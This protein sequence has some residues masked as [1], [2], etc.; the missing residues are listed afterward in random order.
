MSINQITCEEIPSPVWADH[1]EFVLDGFIEVWKVSME[2]NMDKLEF[3]ESLLDKDERIRAYR[4]YHQRDRIRFIIGRGMLRMLLGK[5]LKCLPEEIT[6]S[7]GLN[8]KPFV[9]L[10][11]DL[12][13]NVSYSSSW[14]AMAFSHEEIGIDLEFVKEDFDYALVMQSC[15]T[16]EEIRV[17][18]SAP[19][20]PYRFFRSWTRKEALLK[21]TSVGLNDHLR[22]FSCLDGPQPALRKLG[23]NED[24][25]ITSF[26][27][28]EGYYMS[29][30][31]KLGGAIRYCDRDFLKNFFK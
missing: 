6:F 12:R 16:E 27:M 11:V 1:S 13:F 21:A 7:K 8:H 30:A 23:I 3:L 20:P 25:R 22:E 15:F 24:W 26:L 14:V 9:A 28:E 18:E 29:L 4:Y 2:D 5:Y 19:L 17:I 10:P 31:Q